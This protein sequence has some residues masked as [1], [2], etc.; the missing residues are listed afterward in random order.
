MA[1]TLGGSFN[2]YFPYHSQ[3]YHKVGN[4]W[5]T[6]K[7]LKSYEVQSHVTRLHFERGVLDLDIW[8]AWACQGKQRSV[9]CQTNFIVY[10]IFANNCSTVGSQNFSLFHVIPL[11]Y[12]L[13]TQ[14]AGTTRNYTQIVSSCTF[15]LRTGRVATFLQT[16][17]TNADVRKCIIWENFKWSIIIRFW[18]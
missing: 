11:N 9:P 15:R 18:K 17:T 3:T 12:R 2:P 16:L 4:L 1:K 14:F 10:C 6:S 13:L 5:K 7:L 8:L